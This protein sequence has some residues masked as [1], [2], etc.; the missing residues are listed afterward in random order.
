MMM[1]M[2]VLQYA[3]DGDQIEH[4]SI[5][6]ATA[7]GAVTRHSIS[8]SALA[9]STAHRVRDG[10]LFIATIGFIETKKI[11]ENAIWNMQEYH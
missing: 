5:S 4:Y 9:E 11:K 10:E 7:L 8:C 1:M 6:M 2:F 3:D